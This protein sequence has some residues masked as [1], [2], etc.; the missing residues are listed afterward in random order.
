[1]GFVFLPESHEFQ[2]WYPPDVEQAARAHFA[3]LVRELN[4]PAIDARNWMEDRFLADGF[5]LSRVGAGS[6]TERFGSAIAAAF[7]TDGGQP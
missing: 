1:M 7:R 3:E 5:H 6:F 4:V 2:G